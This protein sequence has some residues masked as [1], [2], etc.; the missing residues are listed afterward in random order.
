MDNATKV[1]TDHTNNNSELYLLIIVVKLTFLVVWKLIRMCTKIYV[2]HN[3]NVIKTHTKKFKRFNTSKIQS[4]Q[5]AENIGD[6][7]EIA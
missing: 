1:K 3:R 2:A 5:E 4:Q 7:N 6:I